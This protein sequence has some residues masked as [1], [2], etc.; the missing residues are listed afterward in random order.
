MNL[1]LEAGGEE[2]ID[3]LV[4]VPDRVLVGEVH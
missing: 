2:A 4:D 3:S 1:A